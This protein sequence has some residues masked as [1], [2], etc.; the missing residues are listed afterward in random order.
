MTAILDRSRFSTVVVY[1][2]DSAANSLTPAHALDTRDVLLALMRT[3]MSSEWDRIWLHFASEEAVRSA[4]VIDPQPEPTE[5]WGP[6]PLSAT[7][8]SALATAVRLAEAYGMEFVSV[9]MV[10]VGLVSDPASAAASALT[11]GDTGRHA[12][13]LEAV[14]DAIVG[15][16]LDGLDEV[17]REP[18]RKSTPQGGADTFDEVVDALGGDTRLCN[19]DALAL[20]SGALRTV[21]DEELKQ[22]Y[23]RMLLNADVVD[24]VRPMAAGLGG[25]SAADLVERAKDRFDTPRPDARQLIVAATH[26]PSQQMSR[27]TWLLG[28]PPKA[29]AFEAADADA[30]ASRIGEEVTDKTTNL[31]VLMALL[32]LATTVFIVRY[33]VVTQN[34]WPDILIGA[35]LVYLAWTGH[36]IGNLLLVGALWFWADTAAVVAALAVTVVDQMLVRSELQNALYRTGIALTTTQWRRHVR[37]RRR[38][39]AWIVTATILWRRQRRQAVA[40][41]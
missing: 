33:V 27:A 2:L 16:G 1:A 18:S 10:T 19:H 40:F 9:G 6:A 32:S 31:T 4:P 17:L 5:R 20:L 12:A 21:D 14:Q 3:D 8:A 26:P 29:I 39:Q 11:G 28:F 35:V 38:S 41:R 22:R 7:C 37:L 13:L 23:D 15:G 25:P 34:W 30:R 36:P 24:A